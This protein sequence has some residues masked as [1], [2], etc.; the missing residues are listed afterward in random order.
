MKVSTI[1]LTA[2][3]AL[4][5]ASTVPTQEEFHLYAKGQIYNN[6]TTQ[7]CTAPRTLDNSFQNSVCN[8]ILNHIVVPMTLEMFKQSSSYENYIL[9]SRFIVEGS[10]GTQVVAIG[11]FNNIWI[12]KNNLEFN[13]PNMQDQPDVQ[14]N[15][16]LPPA[17]NMP[18]Q[19]EVQHNQDL[20]PAHNQD[21]IPDYRSTPHPY[22]T[23]PHDDRISQVFFNEAF[24]YPQWAKDF[25]TYYYD[26]INERDYFASWSMLSP[27]FQNTLTYDEYTRFWDTIANVNVESIEMVS[28]NR[29]HVIA[30]VNITYTKIDGEAFKD[31]SPYIHLNIDESGYWS[32]DKKTKTK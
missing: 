2:S 32:L 21:F 12:T 15:Q 4:I 16:D 25:I 19:L 18:D 30:K 26:M 11:A 7:I 6:L 29:S 22:E 9:F 28:I 20:P 3:I 27:D 1:L 13:T 31:T 10:N 5:A 8:G 23:A 17:H 14:Q 24:A